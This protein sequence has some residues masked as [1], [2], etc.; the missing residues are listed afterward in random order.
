[1]VSGVFETVELGDPD[2]QHQRRCVRRG[3]NQSRRSFDRFVLSVFYHSRQ[4]RY[5]AGRGLS[6]NT[7]KNN[8]IKQ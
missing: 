2:D 6:I 7:E 4:V 1:M 5:T 3:G 8:K